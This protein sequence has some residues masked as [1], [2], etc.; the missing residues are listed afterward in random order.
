MECQPGLPDGNFIM[1]ASAT[2]GDKKNN[3]QFS[4]CSIRNISLV[5]SEVCSSFWMKSILRTKMTLMGLGEVVYLT[6]L[7]FGR[8]F[9]NK[10]GNTVIWF[11]R[12]NNMVLHCSLF[13]FYVRH[14]SPVVLV[15]TVLLD[16]AADQEKEIALE[17]SL[18]FSFCFVYLFIFLIFIFSTFIFCPPLNFV[19]VSIDW[20]WQPSKHVPLW[21]GFV[22]FQISRILL[23]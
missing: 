21:H 7:F 4:S 15:A 10:T 13:R 16:L 22:L 18:L 5:L 3:A 8:L 17:V 23:F 14:R 11:L 12:S 1:F 2:S 19:E 20:L 6:P 9:L